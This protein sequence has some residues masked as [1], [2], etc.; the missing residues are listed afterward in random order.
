M[1]KC[2][3]C[4]RENDD[5][6]ATCSECGT[7]LLETPN[8]TKTRRI[9]TAAEVRLRSRMLLEGLFEASVAVV[10]FVMGWVYPYWFTRKDPIMQTDPD[11]RLGPVFLFSL[12]LGV[13]FASLAVKNFWRACRK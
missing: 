7:L 6:L 2:S 4:G 11:T 8:Q 9:L 5:T 13:I 3:Y 1:K 12:A 10:I